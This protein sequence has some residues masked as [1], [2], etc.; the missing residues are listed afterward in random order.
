MKIFKNILLLSLFVLFLNN[1]YAKEPKKIL[2]LHS[3]HEHLKWTANINKGINTIIED[4]FPNAEIYLEY[5]DTKRYSDLLHTENLYKT[6]LHKFSKIKFD[7]IFTSDN[8]AFEFVK[9]HNKKLFHESPVVFNGVNYLKKEDT[10]GF[11]NFTGISEVHDLEKNYNLVKKIYPDVKNIVIISD[12]SNTGKRIRKEIKKFI[13][14][15]ESNQINYAM[16]NDVTLE[17]LIKKVKALPKDSILIFTSFQIDK[18]N[19]SFN[20]YEVLELLIKE[21]DIPIFGYTHIQLN[22]GIIGG[23]LNSGYAHGVEAG[24]IGLSILLGTKVQDIPNKYT[25]S[26]SYYFDYIQLK[27][28]HIDMENLPLNSQIINKPFSFYETYKML[29]ISTIII[30]IILLIL[31]SALL[32]NVKQR[33]KVELTLLNAREDLKVFNRD[34]EQKVISR[35]KK[36]QKQNDELKQAQDKLIESEKMAS[37]GSLVAGVAHEINTPIGI[38]LTAVTHL[39]DSSKKI[40]DSYNDDTMTESAFENYIKESNDISSL[41]HRNIEKTAELVRSFKRI[42]VDQTSEEKRLFHL[43]QYTHEITSSL[44]SLIKQHNVNIT[45]NCDKE[46]N[47]YSYA[48]AFSQVMTNLIINSINHAFTKDMNKKISI[49]ISSDNEQICIEY[50]DNGKGISKKNQGKIFD[51]FFT[52]N[53]KGGGTGLGLNIIYNIMVNTFNGSI[54]CESVVTQGTTFTIIIPFEGNSVSNEKYNNK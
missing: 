41:L 1:L 20:Y 7:L 15:Q 32:F 11:P 48:G 18:D 49:N 25:S 29:V 5:M 28:F 36:I 24:K 39:K 9:K 17:E 10:L 45:I 35:T 23:Y 30:I 37:L 50:K 4:N 38:C 44:Q 40:G 52:T 47:L 34:L 3:Y 2:I 43:A 27:K 21:I 33:K 13:K 42:A 6:F 14:K 26:N 16:I 51:P 31:L 22:H 53:R 12:S 8:N 19:K 54:K 46:L